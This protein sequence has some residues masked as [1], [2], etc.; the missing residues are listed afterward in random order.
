MESGFMKEQRSS[1]CT[2]SA[3]KKAP[4]DPFQSVES[5]DAL[6]WPG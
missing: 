3:Q 6:G 2:I 1:L 4:Q 5:G